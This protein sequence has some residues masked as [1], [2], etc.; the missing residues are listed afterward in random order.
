MITKAQHYHSLSD[1]EK[2]SHWKKVKRPSRWPQFL[3]A[4]SYAEKLI[5]VYDFEACDWVVLTEKPGHVFGS[6]MCCM[7]GLLMLNFTEKT[8]LVQFMS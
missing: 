2:L 8:G 4:L 5:E 7:Q 6:A 1:E 3:A